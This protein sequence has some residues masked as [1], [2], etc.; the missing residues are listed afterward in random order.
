MKSINKNMK[1]SEYVKCF[2]LRN[3]LSQVD[4]S[5]ITLYKRNTIS[6]WISSTREPKDA[7]IAYLDVLE[8][9]YEQTNK[10]G[11][12]DIKKIKKINT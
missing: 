11:R 1:N 6:Q 10:W 5:R 12:P 4:L 9:R 8:K 7:V 2:L 3:N